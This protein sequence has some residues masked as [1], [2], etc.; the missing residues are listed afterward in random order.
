MTFQQVQIPHSV[1][2]GRVPSPAEVV[3]GG[4]AVNLVD[5][6]LF[7]K[8]YQGNVVELTSVTSQKIKDALG[9]TPAATNGT[10]LPPPANDL[11]TAITLLN[12][13]RS[14]LISSGIGK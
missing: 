7:S 2:Q 11:A 1:V 14:V 10:E 6:R 8:D 5:K 4:L 3:V 13:I 9:F 12:A